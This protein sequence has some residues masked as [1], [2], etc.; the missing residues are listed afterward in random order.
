[1]L[2]DL[3]LIG[4]GIPVAR[5]AHPDGLSSTVIDIQ[6]LSVIRARVMFERLREA[7]S[8]RFGIQLQLQ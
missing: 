4:D 3:R 2:L 1:M 8:G 6:D 7:F 5:L